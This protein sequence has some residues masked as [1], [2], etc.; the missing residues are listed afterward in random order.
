LAGEKLNGC[1]AY[2]RKI[3]LQERRFASGCCSS[4][5][6]SL[7]LLT[8]ETGFT[9]EGILNSTIMIYEQMSIQL[10][11]FRSSANKGLQ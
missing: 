1:K 8:G 10:D 6:V 5:S 2:V 3:I 7:V 4:F 9:D 11:F